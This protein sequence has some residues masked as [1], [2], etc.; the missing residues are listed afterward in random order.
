M[1]TMEA[2]TR[3]PA[4]PRLFGS[5]A[6]QDE[7]ARNNPFLLQALAEEKREGQRIA[8]VART[9]ALVLIGFLL[10]Y[11]NPTWSVLY[12]EAMLLAF[13]GIGWLQLR[14]ATVGQSRLELAL[15][16]LDLVL[17]TFI[18]LVPNPFAEFGAPT[19]MVYRFDN[20]IYFFI[21]LAVGT[22]AYSWRTVWSM[23]TWVAALWAI[24]LVG[25]I[26]LGEQMPELTAAAQAAFSGN[27]FLQQA[28]DPNS[29]DVPHRVQE[30]VV[31]VI[32]A[33]I[34]ALKGWR[35]NQLLMRQAEVAAERANLSRYFP[36]RIVNLLASSTHDIGS[37]RTQNVAVL[38]ADIVGFTPIAENNPPE[39]VMTLLRRYHSV[40]ERAIFENGGTLDKYLGDG[41][42][43]TFGTPEAGPED[44]ANAFRAGWRIVEDMVQCSRECMEHG[45]PE[46]QV[47]VG[48]HYG[49]VIIGDIGPARRLE[50]A[51]VGDTVNVANRLEAETRRLGCR[52]I[53]SDEVVRRIANG[54][55][56]IA[57]F[58]LRR[59]VRLRGR[60]API[61]IWVGGS[62]VAASGTQGG[63][64]AAKPRARKK[65][66]K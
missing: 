6:V 56:E 41:V 9:A 7:M 11:I 24:G 4:L 47:S 65:R 35:S 50:F 28:L 36:D 25:V 19:A 44:A 14:V 38:F 12:Y 3:L 55:R 37:V 51:V 27:P 64:A 61:D 40:I 5:R 53:V 2:T 1:A 31:F 17:L 62:D 32:V 18:C 29:T 13:I 54:A 63:R 21:L 16:L 60:S 23:G 33:G 46:F 66:E 45:D 43:A 52:M 34:L 8:A 58:R 20:F 49:P 15:I 26:F 22:L 48:V 39:K 59:S 10:P 42:M 30:I 57:H